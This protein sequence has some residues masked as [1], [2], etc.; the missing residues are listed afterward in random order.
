[1]YPEMLQ[2]RVLIFE[3]DAL[4][5]L[6]LCVCGL[7]NSGS[8]CPVFVSIFVTGPNF[9]IVVAG[10]FCPDLVFRTFR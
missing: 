9:P 8:V 4:I 1:M 7:T 10:T 6:Y 3:Y 2:T 5:Q